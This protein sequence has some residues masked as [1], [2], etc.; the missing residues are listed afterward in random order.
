MIFEIE[1]FSDRMGKPQKAKIDTLD[2]LCTLCQNENHKII[3]DSRD[4]TIIIWDDGICYGFDDSEY[5]C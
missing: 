4:Q 3:F 1:R 2:E 5:C